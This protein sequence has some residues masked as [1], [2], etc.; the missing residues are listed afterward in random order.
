MSRNILSSVSCMSANRSIEET[1][2]E[3]GQIDRRTAMKLEVVWITL[4]HNLTLL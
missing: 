1:W 4:E 2:I 3:Q